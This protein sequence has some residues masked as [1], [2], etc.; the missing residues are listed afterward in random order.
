MT[1][2]EV[3]DAG[4][5][6]AAADEATLLLKALAHGD[7]LLIL[8]ELAQGERCVSELAG[9]LGIEQPALS[10]QLTVLRANGLV[11]ARRDG[12]WIYYSISDRNALAV[13]QTLYRRFC[14]ADK[15]RAR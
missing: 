6:R 3:L 7:R 10:Q 8:C 5:M 15:S 1:T 13:L 9:E 12:K 11:A 4:K 14:G 2:A